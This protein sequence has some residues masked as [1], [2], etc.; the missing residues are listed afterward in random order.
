MNCTFLNLA[1]F[2]SSNRMMT[3]SSKDWVKY[4]KS[5]NEF[6]FW[7]SD[8][9]LL[10][11]LS[12]FAKAALS[13][14]WSSCLAES[15]FLRNKGFNLVMSVI[16]TCKLR[17]ECKREHHD[18]WTFSQQHDSSWEYMAVIFDKDKIVLGVLMYQNM[19]Y[20]QLSMPNECYPLSALV[21]LLT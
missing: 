20:L 9:N 3:N 8:W 11:V 19:K 7:D 10:T 13:E 4:D 14:L 1:V 18:L 15:T 5:R 16:G 2:I 17:K 21:P 6:W 12:R